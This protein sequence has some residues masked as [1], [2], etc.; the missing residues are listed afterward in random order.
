MIPSEL[1]GCF[2]D[3]DCSK[4]EPRQY[5]RYTIRRVLEYGNQRAVAWLQDVFSGNE[6]CSVIRDERRLSAKSASF[7]GIVYGIPR[8]QISAPRQ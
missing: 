1:H 7:W 6:I 3:I 2:W 4:F 5:P 8:N